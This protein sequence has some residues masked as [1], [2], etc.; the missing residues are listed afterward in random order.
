MTAA[1]K[2]G[3]TKG[4]DREDDLDPRDMEILSLFLNKLHLP[5]PPEDE[6][7]PGR[8]APPEPPDLLNRGSRPSAGREH[9]LPKRHRR[10]L[11]ENTGQATGY[12][13]PGEDREMKR[14]GEM[15]LQ[16][17]RFFLGTP[18]APRTLEV[19]G[20]ERLVVNLRAFDCFTLVET[21]SALA[22]ALLASRL[23]SSPPGK[24]TGRPAA[25]AKTPG[26]RRTTKISFGEEF[27]P[28]PTHSRGDAGAA[29]FRRRGGEGRGDIVAAAG[30]DI[31]AEYH[32]RSFLALLRRLRYRDGIIAG[33][34]SRLHY[35]SDWLENNEAAGLLQEV[36]AAL[37][38]RPARKLIYFMSRHRELY[39]P[40]GNDPVWEEIGDIERRLSAGRRHFLPKEEITCWEGRV[41]PGD[42]LAIATHRRGLDIVHAGLAIWVAGRLHLLHA[43]TTA[44]KVIV[45]PEPLGVYLHAEEYR[46]GIVVA[47]LNFPD[48]TFFDEPGG[49][50]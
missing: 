15:L 9:G 22:L 8:P 23:L 29:V 33:Y 30:K 27:S 28:A 49:S 32:I 36:T 35:F 41:A 20:P 5:L 11:G 44:G 21:C 34:A 48:T 4:V 25:A 6:A 19:P 1:R 7:L 50:S 47:R 39:P 17:G 45:S 12:P 31:N 10:A 3:I 46:A 38:G 16:A 43:S 18:Y 40:P 13:P 14:P 37:G 42:I 26:S 2:A 24:V